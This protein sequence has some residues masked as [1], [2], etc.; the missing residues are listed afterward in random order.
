M[1]KIILRNNLWCSL[2]PS[3]RTFQILVELQDH[4]YFYQGVPIYHFTHFTGPVYQSSAEINYN[5]ACT[6]GM[7]L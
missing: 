7:D 3:G 6:E 2:I 1:I 5:S 4:I